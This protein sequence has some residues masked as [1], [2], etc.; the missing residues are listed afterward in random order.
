MGAPTMSRRWP[1]LMPSLPGSGVPEYPACGA[2]TSEPKFAGSSGVMTHFSGYRPARGET[3]RVWIG[4]LC[5]TTSH[6]HT[7]ILVT[8]PVEPFVDVVV[9]A[10]AGHGV[11]PGSPG[12]RRRLRHGAV[13]HG[14]VSCA[15]SWSTGVDFLT[16]PCRSGRRE[17]PGARSAAQY[18]GPG[19]PPPFR[20]GGPAA[21]SR[22]DIPYDAVLCRGVLN[23]VL[24]DAERDECVLAACARPSAPAGCSVLDV[25]DWKATV[26]LLPHRPGVRA[27]R[28][29]TRLR[30]AFPQQRA[31]AAGGPATAAG[32]ADHR[33]A[34]PEDGV[35]G[36]R[37]RHALLV[38]RGTAG[39][40]QIRR[41][42][43]A[44]RASRRRQ[45]RRRSAALPRGPLVTVRAIRLS[46]PSFAARGGSGQHDSV[47]RTLTADQAACTVRY[48]V[49]QPNRSGRVERVPPSRAYVS[50]ETK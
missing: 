22:S 23:D 6:G 7:T 10:F 26:A 20:R 39:A 48:S 13:L 33:P 38:G 41:L 50:L 45:S 25:R 18:V 24:Q 3:H 49:P 46:G 28:A 16:E 1:G 31:A 40:A 14:A 8:D 17:S 5:T 2:H 35:V 12:S 19:F 32:R 30:A 47:P 27:N 34:R 29:A 4:D 44:C 21:S 9:N 11:E 37:L 43:G 36:V 42:R 15:A